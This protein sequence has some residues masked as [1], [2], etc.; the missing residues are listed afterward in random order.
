MVAC[1]A[2]RQP[3]AVVWYYPRDWSVRQEAV[4]LVNSVKHSLLIAV[5]ILALLFGPSLARAQSSTA[6]DLNKGVIELYR[7]GKFAQAVPLAQQVLAIREKALGPEHPDVALALNNL[8]GLY[9]DQ[10]RYAEAEPL[11]KRALAIYEKALGPDHP[12]VAL[13]LNNLAALYDKQGRTAEAEPLHKRALAVFEKAL[14]PDHRDVATAL[15][16]LASL[17]DDQGRY[18]EAEPLLKRALAI[19]EKALGPD[20]PDVALSLNNLAALYDDQGR[21]AEPSR[22]TSGRWRSRRRRSGPTIP[23]SRGR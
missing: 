2:G 14:G 19:Y 6:D 7:A 11:Y 22:F 3:P 21:Y 9:D 17:Y 23:L 16:S 15:N 12:D 13:A 20:H 5:A 8:A 4:N 18:A 1:Q 10:G